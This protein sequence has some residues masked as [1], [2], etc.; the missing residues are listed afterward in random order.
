[1]LILLGFNV[2]MGRESDEFCKIIFRK[3]RYIFVQFPTPRQHCYYAM[4]KRKLLR[5]ELIIRTHLSVKEAVYYGNK[6]TL[7]ETK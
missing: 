4:A 1:M 2:N 3:G 7:K 5:D 6:E